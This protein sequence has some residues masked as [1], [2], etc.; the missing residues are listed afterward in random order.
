MTE[1][2]AGAP[3]LVR[4]AKSPADWQAVRSLCCRT[5]NGG[6]PIDPARW[7]LFAELWIGPY[8]RLLPKWTYV[9]EADGCVAGYLTGCPDTAAFRRA[10]RFRITLPL[11]VAIAC[12]RYPWNADAR[13]TVRLAFRLDR[14]LESRLAPAQPAGLARTYP[15]H[16]HMNVEAEY[17][18]RGV[19]AAL[20]ERCARDLAAAGVPGIHLLC[21]AG[22]RPF[23]A[24]NGFTDLAAVETSPG[25]LVYTLGRRLCGG[26]RQV[27]D[28]L[29]AAGA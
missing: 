28:A 21:G 14:G 8:Q 4:V 24:R 1:A 9:A 12:G 18:R 20:I 26:G 23:Y 3:V 22:P 5:G 10:R 6:D 29:T 27:G 19:G 15:A 16:L 7:P 11:L 2:G 13:R 25:R 17:R